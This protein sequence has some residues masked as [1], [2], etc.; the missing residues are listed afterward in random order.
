MPKIQESANS[1]V[2]I[3]ETVDLTSILIFHLFSEADLIS[4]PYQECQ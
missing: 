1:F 4:D 2:I 3:F